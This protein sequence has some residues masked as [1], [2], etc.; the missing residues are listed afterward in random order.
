MMQFLPALLLYSDCNK[1]ISLIKGKAPLREEL[2]SPNRWVW[3]ICSNNLVF[4][5]SVY[6]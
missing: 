6:M 4:T 5:Y 3:T 1:L 2:I